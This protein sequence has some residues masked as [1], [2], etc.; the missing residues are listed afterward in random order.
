VIRGKEAI[1]GGYSDLETAVIGFTPM[2]FSPFLLVFVAAGLFF[3]LWRL[4]CHSWRILA[5]CYLGLATVLVYLAADDRVLRHPIT[6]KEISPSS[7]GAQASFEVLMRYSLEQP[8]WKEFQGV[9]VRWRMEPRQ[10]SVLAV[11]DFRAPR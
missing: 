8:L 10:T 5:V 6:L 1:L 4:R 3:L 7:P 2:L 9:C 11:D